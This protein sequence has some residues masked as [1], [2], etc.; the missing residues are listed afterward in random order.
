MAK[1]K[2]TARRSG[3]KVRA[4]KPKTATK[5][6][7]KK[8]RSAKTKRK[9][10]PE[11]SLTELVQEAQSSIELSRD[12]KGVPRWSIKVYGFNDFSSL[13]EALQ[14]VLKLDKAMQKATMG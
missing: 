2:V 14:K 10:Q 11:V 8:T 3:R 12:A 9:A 5:T 7:S 1:K 13:K 4:V 6:K